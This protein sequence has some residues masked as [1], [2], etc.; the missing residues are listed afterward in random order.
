M[1]TPT[2][3]EISRQAY[4][5]WRNHECPAG[6][7]TEFWLEAERKLNEDPAAESAVENPLSTAQPEQKSIQAAMQKERARAPQVA[8]HTVPKTLPPQTGKPLWPQPHSS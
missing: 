2:H 4:Q 8:Q 7:D 1:N 3:D 5:L 6:R